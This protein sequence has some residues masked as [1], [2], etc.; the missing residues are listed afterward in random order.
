MKSVLILSTY[1]FVKPYHGGQIR[2]FNIA[3]AYERA[4]I[5]TVRIACYD[6]SSFRIEEAG[7]TDIPICNHALSQYN[8]SFYNLPFI[9]DYE[10]GLLVS[11][12]PELMTRI[13]NICKKHNIDCIHLEQPWLLPVVK[14]I[15]LSLK[16]KVLLVYGS[17]N[18]EFELKRQLLYSYKD[19]YGI[20]SRAISDIINKIKDLEIEAFKSAD[21]SLAVSE[22]DMTWAINNNVKKVN[23]LLV[24]NGV[25]RLT[26][27]E[28]LYLKIKK[29]TQNNIL[30]SFIASAHPPNFQGFKECMG[31]SLACIPPNGKLIVG[32]SVGP[33]IESILNESSLKLLNIERFINLGKSLERE[34]IDTLLLSSSAVILPITYG[35]GS[36]LKTAEA[37]VAGKYIIATSKAMSGY[38]QYKN[39]SG[40]MIRDKRNDFRAALTNVFSREPL[41]RTK[42]ENLLVNNLYWEACT[43]GLYDYV[44]KHYD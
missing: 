28:K 32:G 42:A 14:K 9:S 23:I 17:Q 35:G 4:G 2:L 19:M 29:I 12:T 22:S 24:P 25:H 20:K 6:E 13:I 15:T 26:Y 18:I 31:N 1:P 40:L 34:L 8:K 41:V 21:L 11:N 44:R 38:E 7:E 5:H 3:K 10:S 43:L 36:N 39:L 37:I 33:H 27:N 16:N 30:V